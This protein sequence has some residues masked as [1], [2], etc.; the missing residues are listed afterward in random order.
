[1][2]FTCTTDSSLPA[3]WIHWYIGGKNVTNLAQPQA[4]HP[5]Q[6]KYISSSIFVYTGEIAD[7]NKDIFCEA[8]NKEGSYKVTSQKKYIY[9]QS[10]SL[11]VN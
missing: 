10:K 11:F 3:A 9:V 8:V 4:P 2:T 1:M 7:H 5:D 6:L